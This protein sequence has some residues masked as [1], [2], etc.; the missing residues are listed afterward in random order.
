MSRLKKI[1]HSWEEA[2]DAVDGKRVVV[3]GIEGHIKID[4]RP[5]DTRFLVVPTAKGRKT[6]AYQTDRRYLHD[7]WN[8]NLTESDRAVRLAEK[9]VKFEGEPRPDYSGAYS[10][11]ARGIQGR[12]SPHRESPSLPPGTRKA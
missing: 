8:F 9:F 12:N 7:D 3:D 5:N 1:V 4:Y 2:C 10:R 6:E 11:A